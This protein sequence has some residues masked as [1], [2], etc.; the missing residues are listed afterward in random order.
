[1]TD[2]DEWD[3]LL[4]YIF[5]PS[6]LSPYNMRTHELTNH[7]TFF[8]MLQLLSSLTTVVLLA[9]LVSLASCRPTEEESFSLIKGESLSNSDSFSDVSLPDYMLELGSAITFGSAD[10]TVIN[11]LISSSSN[12]LSDASSFW[13]AA[14]A[15]DSI[16]PGNNRFAYCCNHFGCTFTSTCADGEAL[17]CCTGDGGLEGRSYSDCGEAYALPNAGFEL[18]QFE[19]DVSGNLKNDPLAIGN[20][21]QPLPNEVTLPL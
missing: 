20:I 9:S 3:V 19:T 17:Q 2:I 13:T 12:S 15:M 1:M 11:S 8:E 21:L 16:C 18:F 10:S 5:I 4:F 7:L 14:A 6:S